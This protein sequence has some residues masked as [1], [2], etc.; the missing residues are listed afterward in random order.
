MESEII[1]WGPARTTARQELPK[2]RSGEV[3]ERLR[4]DIISG[5]LRPGTK[6]VSEQ[7]KAVYGVGSSPLREALSHLAAAGLVR[8]EDQ[9]GVRVVEVSLGELIDV[10]RLR[11]RLE[12]QAIQDSI[13]H[14]GV[15]WEVE[16]ISSFHRLQHLVA[17]AGQGQGEG[18]YPEDRKYATEWETSHRAFHFAI[19]GGCCSP[20]L[21]HFC[22]RLYDQTERYRRIFVKYEKIPAD[23]LS[24]HKNLMDM[25]LARDA[26]GVCNAMRRHIL[27]AAELT[28]RDMRAD[29]VADADRFPVGLASFIKA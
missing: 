22:D 15:D 7:V 29:G 4:S 13:E 16:V 1:T 14:G 28:E 24:E 20:W 10:V 26:D 12:I 27:Y 21:L 6:L 23:L 17:R 3:F 8:A 19:M 2:T 25:A 18:D 11:L 9:K 5:R